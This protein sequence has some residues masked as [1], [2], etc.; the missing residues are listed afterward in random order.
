MIPLLYQLSYTAIKMAALPRRDFP[1]LTAEGLSVISI[2]DGLVRLVHHQR[3]ELW[4]RCLR[5][6]CSEPTELMVH[7]GA[8]WIRTIASQKDLQVTSL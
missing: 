4:T 1:V 6:N 2:A 7:S 5:G 3:L 8:S